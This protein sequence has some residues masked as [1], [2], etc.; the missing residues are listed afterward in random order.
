MTKQ[1]ITQIPDI[2]N[3]ATFDEIKSALT[4]WMRNQEEFKDFDFNGAGINV[5][6]DLLAYNTL[7]IQQFAN[8]ALYESFIRT[9]IKRSSVVQA[10]QD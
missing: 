8:A 4:D 7:Y 3:A 5:L 9:A 1:K 2:F 6:M 10:A